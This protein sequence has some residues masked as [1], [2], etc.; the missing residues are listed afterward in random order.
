MDANLQPKLPLNQEL[1]KATYGNNHRRVSKFVDN[2]QEKYECC[3]SAEGTRVFYRRTRSDVCKFCTRSDCIRDKL[4]DDIEGTDLAIV[5][6]M[7]GYLKMHGMFA[8]ED[9]ALVNPDNTVVCQE[10]EDKIKL[11]EDEI[12]SKYPGLDYFLYRD[13]FSATS[14]E[15]GWIERSPYEIRLVL[16]VRLVEMFP[17]YYEGMQKCLVNYYKIYD[18]CIE[19]SESIPNFYKVIFST[20]HGENWNTYFEGLH[21]IMI[22][23]LLN[24]YNESELDSLDKFFSVLGYSAENVFEKMDKYEVRNMEYFEGKRISKKVLEKYTSF[25]AKKKYPVVFAFAKK[26]LEGEV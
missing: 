17:K 20:V 23:K 3:Q 11:L 24:K 15:Y 13:L 16:W 25:S 2:L 4:K 21:P 10:K 22:S 6:N 5:R 1:L 7:I 18:A 12:R 19:A 14:K 8:Y 9:Y 26:K